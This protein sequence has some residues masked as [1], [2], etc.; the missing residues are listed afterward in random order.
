MTLHRYILAVAVMAATNACAA[1]ATRRDPVR[2]V[3]PTFHLVNA[4]FDS[5]TSLA[6]APAGSNAF[7]NVD[8]GRPLQGGFSEATFEVPA[9]GC[10]RDLR[11]TFRNGR[12]TRLGPIDMCRTHGL[13]LGAHR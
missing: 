4:A 7:T 10:R 8:L 2:Q 6:I 9:G 12:T 3:A 5:I 13:R 1:N 11:I